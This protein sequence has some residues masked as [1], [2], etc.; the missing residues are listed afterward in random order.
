MD[1]EKVYVKFDP[2]YGTVICVHKDKENICKE[3]E[4]IEELRDVFPL[5]A[6]EFVLEE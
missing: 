4:D 6:L 2:L 1:K 5:M 3:C